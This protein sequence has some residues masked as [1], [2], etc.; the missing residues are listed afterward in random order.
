MSKAA[1]LL[2]S[3][4][5]AFGDDDTSPRET[6]SDKRPAKRKRKKFLPR[7]H[8]TLAVIL[9]AVRDEQLIFEL[10]NET[11][12]SGWLYDVDSNLNANLVDATVTGR[13]GRVH[14]LEHT[15]VNGSAIRYVRFPDKIDA[16]RALDR[17]LDTRARISRSQT[18]QKRPEPVGERPPPPAPIV[19]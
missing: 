12:V 10:K 19:L 3:H 15:Y 13:N 5:Q 9:E 6:S 14:R 17:Y 1:R 8:R 11:E 16:V 18:R 2:Y 7:N 4:R